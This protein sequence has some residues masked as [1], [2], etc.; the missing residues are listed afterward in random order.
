MDVTAFLEQ[1][2]EYDA[3]G[4]LRN[5][6]LK[7]LALQGQL[8]PFAVLRAAELR[9]WVDD[10]DYQ[11][12]LGG[13]Y[14][15]RGTEGDASMSDE[16]REAARSYKQTMDESADAFMRVLRSIGEEAVSVGQ[17]IGDRIRTDRTND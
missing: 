4:D 14:P 13:D 16:A 17:R 6:V 2:R 9:R 10:G 11:R 8:H 15:R 3:Q 1:A 7:L 5:G 12:V